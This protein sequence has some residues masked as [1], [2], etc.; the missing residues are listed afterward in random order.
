[1]RKVRELTAVERREIRRLV[2]RCA[3]YDSEYGCLP[4]DGGCYMLDL[5]WTGSLC[6]YFERAV[7]PVN[8][9]LERVLKGE[10]ARETKPCVVCGRRFPLAGRRVYCSERCRVRGQRV[11]DARRAREYR[12]RKN[13]G[14]TSRF[15]GWEMG[16]TQG[17]QVVEWWG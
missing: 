5:W 4:L 17:F 12:L 9:E 16:L 14:G 15:R 7:L 1:M 2:R 13:K 11:V 3:N 10:V 6:K 8:P